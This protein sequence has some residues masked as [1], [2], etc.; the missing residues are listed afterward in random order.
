MRTNFVF[1]V[2]L[3]TH[4]PAR[5]AAGD[6]VDAADDC[7]NP[8]R[9]SLP[10]PL[11]GDADTDRS[12]QVRMASGAGRIRL[13]QPAMAAQC[14]WGRHA[15]VRY[16]VS[17]AISVPE[18]GVVVFEFD[19]A[20]ADIFPFPRGEFQAVSTRPGNH[21]LRV[22]V[23][24]HD[25][26]QQLVEARAVLV[27]HQEGRD[28]PDGQ[29]TQ[30]DAEVVLHHALKRGGDSMCAMECVPSEVMEIVRVGAAP[31]ISSRAVNAGAETAYVVQVTNLLGPVTQ[32]RIL[33]N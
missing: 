8:L 6:S 11:T 24:N 19:G 22:A 33:T 27:I 1:W 3:I 32:Q 28:I 26:T 12:P 17:G 21:S 31:H 14:C 29:H 25:R 7:A 9:A 13:S 20:E 5:R 2:L 10:P 18:D 4:I 23:E 30:D 15:I 16:E